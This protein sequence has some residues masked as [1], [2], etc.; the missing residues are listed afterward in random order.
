MHSPCNSQCV[1]ASHC[2]L[3]VAEPARSEGVDEG[4]VLVAR[5]VVALCRTLGNALPV[6]GNLARAQLLP[7]ANQPLFAHRRSHLEKVEEELKT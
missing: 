4:R 7:Q 3:V 2:E 5:G 6:D 1:Y